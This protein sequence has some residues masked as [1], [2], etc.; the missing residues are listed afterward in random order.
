MTLDKVTIERRKQAA[1]LE[2][3]GL[4]KLAEAQELLSCDNTAAMNVVG[5]PVPA[6][7]VTV[8]LADEERTASLAI[9][10]KVASELAASEDPAVLKLAQELDAVA[11]QIEKNAFVYQYD[12]VDPEK[13]IKDS[14]KGGVIEAPKGSKDDNFLQHFKEDHTHVVMQAV[15]KVLPFQKVIKG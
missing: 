2:L 7:V 5:D 9:L 14:F 11:S 8:A 1:L 3:E 15:K 10:D 13:E 4:Q 12:Y 6:K